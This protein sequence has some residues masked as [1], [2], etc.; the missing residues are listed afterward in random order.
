MISWLRTQP[1]DVVVLQEV[2]PFIDK[3]LAD[4]GDAY[5]FT[6]RI[7]SSGPRL[8]GIIEACQG[9]IVLSTVP[10]TKATAF[11]PI[12]TAWPA[13]FAS[14][15]VSDTQH[16]SL[17][18]V[19][20][21]DPIR[22]EGLLWRDQ[23]FDLLAAHLNT[24]HGPLIVL[25]DF[26]A[27]PY[28]PAFRDFQAEAGL[29]ASPWNPATYPAKIGTFGIS[30]DHVLVRD[31]TLLRLDPLPAIGSDHRPLRALIALPGMPEDISGLAD[32]SRPQTH[33]LPSG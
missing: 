13:L 7:S 9:I 15:Q 23:F 16:M 24:I 6:A 21:A 17:A 32:G 8:Q 29:V 4:V 31:A 18:V 12:K 10:I 20:A 30:I 26:N 1:A 33:P 28:T 14:L 19:H 22:A 11:Q 25:G 3:L 5:P 2:P 27:S